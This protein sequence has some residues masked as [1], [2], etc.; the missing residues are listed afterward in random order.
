M[1]DL[2]WVA[3]I[4]IIV[5]AQLSQAKNKTTLRGRPFTGDRQTVST[6]VAVP[7]RAEKRSSARRTTGSEHPRSNVVPSFSGEDTAGQATAAVAVSD[8]SPYDM[9]DLRS[10]V[11]WAEIIAP[12]ISRRRGRM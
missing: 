11:V 2:I 12:P 8:S 9:P 5:I 6:P 3:L 7:D 1:I 4:I 10:A